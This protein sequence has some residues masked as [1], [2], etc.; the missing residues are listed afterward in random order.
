MYMYTP[1]GRWKLFFGG[2]VGEGLSE[3]VGH[4]GWLMGKI[5]QLSLKRDSGT[6]VFL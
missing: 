4:R 5:L 2:E 1:E 3:N 6:G